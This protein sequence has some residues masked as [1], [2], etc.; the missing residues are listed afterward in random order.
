MNNTDMENTEVVKVG[1]TQNPQNSKAAAT[2]AQSVTAADIL[3]RID[4][5]TEQGE[6]LFTVIEQIHDLPVNDS[7]SGGQDGAEWAVAIDEICSAREET[8]QK[9]VGL[10]SRMY[11]DIVPRKLDRHDRKIEILDKI[12]KMNFDAVQPE[13]VKA[14]LN[15]FENQLKDD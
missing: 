6:R 11:D 10:L 9:M 13:A 15:F 8:N 14:V 5:I 7:P 3:A 2:A 12:R 4:R 1:E